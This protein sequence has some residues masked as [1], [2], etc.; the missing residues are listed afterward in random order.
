MK[1]FSTFF[2]FVFDFKLVKTQL[3]ESICLISIDVTL[4]GSDISPQPNIPYFM[5]PDQAF[6]DYLLAFRLG[7]YCLALINYHQFRKFSILIKLAIDLDTKFLELMVVLRKSS[8][9]RITGEMPIL[10]QRP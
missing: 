3:T 9:I 10:H 6:S 2:F 1:N 4:A 8:L 5:C 7:V